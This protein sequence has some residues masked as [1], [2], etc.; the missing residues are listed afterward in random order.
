MLSPRMLGVRRQMGRAIPPHPVGHGRVD[1]EGGSRRRQRRDQADRQAASAR[2][3]NAA[4]VAKLGA[5]EGQAECGVESDETVER[6]VA[7][8]APEELEPRGDIEAVVA[9]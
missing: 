9:M 5:E 4:R 7:Q 8:A 2:A 1:L 6:L 3:A